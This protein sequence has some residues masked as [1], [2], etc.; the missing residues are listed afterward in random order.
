M[1]SLER[2]LKEISLRLCKIEEK[3][4]ELLF[5]SKINEL[6]KIDN[7]YEAIKRNN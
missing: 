1:D 6:D 2:K 4:S 5:G 3:Q 7:K